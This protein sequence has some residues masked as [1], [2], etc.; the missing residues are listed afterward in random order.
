MPP[1][2][3]TIPALRSPQEALLAKDLEAARAEV[4]QARKEQDIERTR[5]KKAIAE[6]KRKMDK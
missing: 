3:P 6:M 5:I 2:I 1:P 4:A